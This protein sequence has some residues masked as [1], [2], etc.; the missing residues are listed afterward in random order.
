VSH[1]DPLRTELARGRSLAAPHVPPA[2]I[3]A[4]W[5]LP[6]RTYLEQ[7]QNSEDQ[8]S[9]R[10]RSGEYDNQA[11]EDSRYRSRAL[12]RSLGCVHTIGLSAAW[13]QWYF[14]LGHEQSC[15]TGTFSDRNRAAEATRLLVV[16]GLP[17][18]LFYPGATGVTTD[19]FPTLLIPISHK[20]D[21]ATSY[22]RCQDRMRFWRAL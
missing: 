10:S 12:G 3:C 19:R 8:S 6:D 5:Q 21:Y 18:K 20:V 17:T 22:E 4:A 14:R 11:Q 16:G 7:V 13:V 9:H 2:L 15:A 1:R